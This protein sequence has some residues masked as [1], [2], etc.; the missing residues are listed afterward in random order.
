MKKVYLFEVYKIT[1]KGVW[2]LTANYR[3][4][5]NDKKK[6]LAELKNKGYR[7]DRKEKAYILEPDPTES[8]C[9]TAV[10]VSSYE[11]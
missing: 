8:V 1:G 4:L 6:K 9:K 10:C 3:L 5:A 11:I 7:Y 2:T